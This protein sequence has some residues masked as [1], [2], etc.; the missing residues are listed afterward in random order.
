MAKKKNSKKEMTIVSPMRERYD[1]YSK[2]LSC[3]EGLTKESALSN[4]DIDEQLFKTDLNRI[5][6]LLNENGILLERTK[7]KITVYSVDGDVDIWALK[8]QM[9]QN[10]TPALFDFLA[11]IPNGLPD[12]FMESLGL[13]YKDFQESKVH[14]SFEINPV[15]AYFEHFPVIYNSINKQ[16]LRI[17]YHT[18]NGKKTEYLFH[19]EFLKQFNTLWYA[20]GMASDLDGNNLKLSKFDILNIDTIEVAA[21]DFVK[22]SVDNYLEYFYDIVGVENYEKRK[23]V[24][25]KLLVKSNMLARFKN[26]PM[27]ESFVVLRNEPSSMK[28]Y[29]NAKIEV[30]LN[31][32]LERKIISYGNDVLVVSPKE[33]RDN[34]AGQVRKMNGFYNS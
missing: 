19:P 11:H 33:L 7:H 29:V 2:K 32:E 15:L 10:M 28:G 4:L 20:F 6:T 16:C 12:E 3:P 21:K 25:V 14:A 30:K 5:E 8:I 9:E 24:E 18:Y 23:V 34:I 17:T 1:F 31:K 26:N 27:H 22:S 13:V